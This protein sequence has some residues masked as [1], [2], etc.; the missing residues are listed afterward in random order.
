V[1]AIFSEIA[2]YSRASRHVA[3]GF[4]QKDFSAWVSIFSKM[5]LVFLPRTAKEYSN[6]IWIAASDAHSILCR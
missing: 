6:N 4:L 3:T 1:R 5:A 2:E